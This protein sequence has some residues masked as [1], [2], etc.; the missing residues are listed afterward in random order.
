MWLPLSK[1]FVIPPAELAINPSAKCKTD[2]TVMEDAVDVRWVRCRICS[3]WLYCVCEAATEPSFHSCLSS[4]SS[5]LN[6]GL[7][8]F[9]ENRLIVGAVENLPTIRACWL[10][11]HWS[12]TLCSFLFYFISSNLWHSWVERV[13]LATFWTIWYEKITFAK[14]LHESKIDVVFRHWGTHKELT[15]HTKRALITTGNSTSTGNAGE[16]RTKCSETMHDRCT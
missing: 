16:P 14:K 6:F 3:L 15:K 5:E 8:Y 9:D 11:L 1:S 4:I 2:M 7:F 12:L 13:R 10:N